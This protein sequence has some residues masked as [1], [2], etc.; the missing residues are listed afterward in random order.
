M[1]SPTGHC[2]QIS[3]DWVEILEE[4]VDNGDL[5]QRTKEDDNEDQES[6]WQSEDDDEYLGSLTLIEKQQQWID[7]GNYIIQKLR[8][9]L[10]QNVA[11]NARLVRENKRLHRELATLKGTIAQQKYLQTLVFP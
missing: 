1:N 7:L 2:D 3:R 4:E 11:S 5:R 10:R 9:R 8:R 6:Q